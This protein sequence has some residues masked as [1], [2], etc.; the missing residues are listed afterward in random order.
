MKH[1]L[2][3]LQNRR[4]LLRARE[5]NVEDKLALKKLLVDQMFN[6]YDSDNNGLVDSNEL[7]QEKAHLTGIK[8]SLTR[9][10]SI[11]PSPPIQS[12][13]IKNW[14]KCPAMEHTLVK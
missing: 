5:R 10:R 8:T 11:V 3:D 1:F 14:D 2:L 6:Y 13:L 12:K 9:A 7:T 4:Y